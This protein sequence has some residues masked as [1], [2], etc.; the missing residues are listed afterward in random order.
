MQIAQLLIGPYGVHVGVYAISFRHFMVGQREAFPFGQ[1]VHHF[2]LG[3]AKIFYRKSDG[4]FRTAQIVIDAQSAQHKEGPCHAA[5]PKPC[6]QVV[7]EKVLNDFNT[8]LRVI[9]TKERFVVFWMYQ[10]THTFI[11]IKN[12]QIYEFSERL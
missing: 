5:Q 6:G 7:L 8:L 3:V 2:R 4:A 9:F 10:V 1:R 11:L 12:A